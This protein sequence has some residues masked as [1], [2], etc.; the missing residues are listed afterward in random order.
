MNLMSSTHPE[1]SWIFSQSDAPR[2][3][4]T[5]ASRSAA[6]SARPGPSRSARASWPATFAPAATATGPWGPGTS[7][8]AQVIDR[9]NR[10]CRAAA[11]EAPLTCARSAGRPVS[12]GLLLQ[13]RLQ[14]L[15]AVSPGELPARSGTDPVLPLRRRAEHQEGR[16]QFL[17]RL[18]SQRSLIYLLLARACAR[19]CVLVRVPVMNWHLVQVS[20]AFALRHLGLAPADPTTLSSGT[21]GSRWMD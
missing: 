11:R 19:V 10:R 12:H 5:T 6:S 2:G 17:P 4:T 18:R 3:R 14:A 8:P 13:R 9:R 16:S 1:P 15:P 7:P 21:S 20:P